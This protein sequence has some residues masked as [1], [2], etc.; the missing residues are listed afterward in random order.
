MPDA[1]YA[2]VVTVRKPNDLSDVTGFGPRIN[3]SYTAS[4]T[5]CQVGAMFGLGTYVDVPN[6]YVAFFR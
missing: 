6:Y 5:Q 3:L 2:F 1:N 4:T